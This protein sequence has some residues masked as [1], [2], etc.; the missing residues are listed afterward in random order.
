[1]CC[2]FNHDSAR[3]SSQTAQQSE[4]VTLPPSA[5]SLEKRWDQNFFYLEVY[6]LKHMISSKQ[7]CTLT[8]ITIN[9]SVG[10]IMFPSV[11][12]LGIILVLLEKWQLWE[13]WVRSNMI[14]GIFEYIY[15][16]P[17]WESIILIPTA[18]CVQ[19]C[20]RYISSEHFYNL[21][22]RV[23][24]FFNHSLHPRFII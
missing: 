21:T 4:C 5:H 18:W 23:F 8:S 12:S 17:H 11:S 20:I 6:S 1:M 2:S 22:G 7:M 13:L 10:F 15:S 19:S 14:Y 3:I 24:F 9:W 16:I